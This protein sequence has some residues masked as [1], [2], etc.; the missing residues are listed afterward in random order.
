MMSCSENG[1]P[2]LLPVLEFLLLRLSFGD[3]K[4]DVCAVLLEPTGLV[5]M[6]LLG[7][8]EQKG[9]ARREG[10]S[11]P[12]ALRRSGGQSASGEGIF[13]SRRFP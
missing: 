5:M 3:V 8:M 12:R 13:A 1:L 11:A 9:G 2:P 10:G 4:D 6:G 7:A